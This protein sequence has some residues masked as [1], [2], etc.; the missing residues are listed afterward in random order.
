MKTLRRYGEVSFYPIKKEVTA[1]D[2]AGV[3]AVIADA[4][5]FADSFYEAADGLRIVA[6]RGVGF[7]S[8]NLE[9]ATRHG[10]LIT[11]AP[12][13]V[14]TV[15]EFSVAM[16]LACM[17]RVFTLNQ[18][19]HGGTKRL[20]SSLEVRGSTLGIYG[21]GRIGQWVARKAL[22]LVGEGGRVLAYDVRPDLGEVC[23]RLGIEAVSDPKTL[24]SESDAVAIH[25]SGAGKLVGPELLACMKPHASLINPS[26]G[27]LVDAGAVKAAILAEKLFY[28]VVDEPLVDE[29]A[30]LRGLERVTATNHCAGIT[31]SSFERL[32]RKCFEQVTDALEGRRPEHIV[33]EEALKHPRVRGWLRRET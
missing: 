20:M 21:L 4:S 32:D 22:P 7:E 26:R 16:W 24:M 25:V 33:N 30:A 10:V 23:A 14:E 5:R 29:L 13:H 31:P 19:G 17:R 8:V 3:I 15:A 1:S 12:E 28:Y 6:R 11:V 2:A 27:G 18:L 9:A